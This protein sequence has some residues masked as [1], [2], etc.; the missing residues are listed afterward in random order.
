MI[1]LD[2]ILF[3]IVFFIGLYFFS[4]NN[5]PLVGWCLF[6]ALFWHIDYAHDDLE[7]KIDQIKK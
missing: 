2:K 1:L 7:K 5:Y 6:F 3:W 4:M